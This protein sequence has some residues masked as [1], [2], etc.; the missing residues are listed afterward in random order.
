VV[1]AS[2]LADSELEAHDLDPAM[3]VTGDLDVRV[4]L[5]PDSD[6]LGPRVR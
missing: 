1:R 2:A 5:L 3:V 4:L 6:D